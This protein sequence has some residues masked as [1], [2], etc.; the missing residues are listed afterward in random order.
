MIKKAVFLLV[1]F[2]LVSCN[3]NTNKQKELSTK[4]QI[5]SKNVYVPHITD[6]DWFFSI[7]HHLEA[8]QNIAGKFNEAIATYNDDLKRLPKNGWSHH[9]LKLACQE[10]E[11]SE[12]IAKMESLIKESWM[13]ADFEIVD[14]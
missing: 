9:G 11:D 12:N 10:L 2:L 7:R 8:I 3:E 4:K 1:M 14:F 5:T 13:D 6:A